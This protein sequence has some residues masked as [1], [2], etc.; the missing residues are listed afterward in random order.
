MEL[1]TSNVTP[2]DPY[3]AVCISHIDNLVPFS[4]FGTSIM[5][6]PSYSLANKTLIR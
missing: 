2:E 4:F 5:L 6:I 1:N 3:F